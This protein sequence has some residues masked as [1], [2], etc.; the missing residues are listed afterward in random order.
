[1]EVIAQKLD[2]IVSSLRPLTVEWGKPNIAV[3]WGNLSSTE[4]LLY[5]RRQYEHF[6]GACCPGDPI[7]IRAAVEQK[8]VAL[9]RN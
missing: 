3:T 5:E 2:D 4:Q 9:S 6:E 7:I 1:M 8:M